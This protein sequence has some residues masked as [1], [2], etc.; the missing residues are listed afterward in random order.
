MPGNE[1]DNLSFTLVFNDEQYAVHTS[2]HASVSLMGLIAGRLGLPG[3][4]LCS[5]MGSCG[6]CR[7]SICDKRDRVQGEALSCMLTIN[8]SLN[9]CFIILP[10]IFY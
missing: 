3:F 4:G 10:E 6:T 8:Q 7:V 2:V 9:G 5:G 1:P